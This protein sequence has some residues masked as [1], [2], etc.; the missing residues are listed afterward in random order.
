MIV[1]D[2]DPG[3]ISACQTM[4]CGTRVVHC[5][6]HA[7][8]NLEKK[9]RPTLGDKWE[10]F[11]EDFELVCCST[12]EG[13]FESRWKAFH[14]KYV[15]N[16]PTIGEYIDALFLDRFTWAWPW[17]RSVFTAGIKSTQRVEKSNH[18]VKVLNNNNSRA[19]ITSIVHTTLDH[20]QKDYFQGI[21][22]T[23]RD[24]LKSPSR[25]QALVVADDSTSGVF[26]ELLRTH[27]ELLDFFARDRMTEELNSAFSHRCEAIDLASL[28]KVRRIFFGLF[29]C[30]LLQ[31]FR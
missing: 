29:I 5:S 8:K 15:P 28:Q 6:W 20:A 17:I 14:R 7:H 30:E 1:T 12:F 22:N 16:H 27:E 11:C 19:S 10:R 23:H 25:K 3:I 24:A 9:C 4:L 2:K 18:L 13:E 31:G 26:R 21:F